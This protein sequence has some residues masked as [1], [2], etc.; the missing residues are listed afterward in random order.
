MPT[1]SS[2]LFKIN[3]HQE[4]SDQHKDDSKSFLYNS[5]NLLD[6]S[7]FGIK[8][9]GDL[10]NTASPH[11]SDIYYK[12]PTFSIESLSS[13][14]RPSSVPTSF[15]GGTSTTSMFHTTSPPT[16]YGSS[17]S[18]SVSTSSFLTLLAKTSNSATSS[19]IMQPKISSSSTIGPLIQL[20]DEN[21]HFKY[22]NLHSLNL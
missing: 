8:Y 1:S 15:L 21:Q 18:E 22:W 6:G 14:T 13:T 4:S 11:N 10:S 5:K 9:S 17:S 3:N 12:S 2:N 7:S 19:S 16:S 20:V